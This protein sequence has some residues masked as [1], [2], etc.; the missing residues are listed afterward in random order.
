MAVDYKDENIPV[1]KIS[2]DLDN[3]RFGHLE[4]RGISATSDEL[5]QEEIEKDPDTIKLIK[6]IMREGVVE[7]ISVRENGDGTYMVFEGNRR[8]TCLRKLIRE[9]A[10]APTG[11]SYNEVK[12]HV[13]PRSYS[14]QKIEILKG[15][16]QTGK[17]S[18]KTSIPLL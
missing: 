11:V 18:W 10:R 1:S 14:K 3:P 16:L 4:L 13:Y 8:T 7:P 12:A 5:M 6:D 15:R 17:K 2:L 9:G